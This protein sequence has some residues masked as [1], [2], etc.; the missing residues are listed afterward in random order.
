MR[1]A[2]CLLAATLAGCGWPEGLPAPRSPGPTPG[3]D[4][5]PVLQTRVGEFHDGRR[6]AA[7]IVAIED[8]ATLADRPGAIDMATAW[9]RYL[10]TT[11]RVSPWRISLLRDGQATAEAISAAVEK[12]H[13]GVGRPGTLWFVFIGH[14]GSTAPGEYGALVLQAGDGARPGL[15]AEPILQRL[16]Y[17]PHAR[18]VVVLDGCL[19]GAGA[20]VLAGS[21]TPTMPGFVA[22]ETNPD[23]REERLRGALGLAR[24]PREPVDAAV[25]SAGHGPGCVEQLPGAQFPALSYL[26][27][28]GLQGWADRDGNGTVTTRELISQ[29]TEMLR[30]ASQGLPTPAPAPRLFGPDMGLAHAVGARAPELRA[31][32]PRAVATDSSG[33]GPLAS[34]LQE[35]VLWTRDTAVHVPRGRFRMGCPSR[36]DRECEA[37]ERPAHSLYVSRF[38]LD[39]REVTHGEYA[40]CVARGLCDPVDRAQC[41]V[42]TGRRFER[43]AP[44]SRLLTRADHPAVCVTW[45]QAQRFCHVHDRRLPTEAEWERAAAGATRRRFP[46]GAAEPDCE[47]AHFDGCG[48]HTRPV[49][50]RPSGATPEGA[51]DMAGNAAEWVHDW[52]VRAIYGQWRD[53][54][55][56]GGKHGQVRVVRGGSYYDGPALLRSSYRY[57]LNPMSSFSTVGFRCLR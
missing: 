24:A 49:R 8:Y 42:W 23:L 56:Y 44:L 50:G 26:L 25:F 5:Y 13:A 37:D 41:F 55:P 21:E 31:W 53:R 30:A 14:V 36:D 57:G 39:A 9:Y 19:P 47:R 40:E 10:R 28:G 52:Y 12:A 1:A 3:G 45:Y 34:L 43:G 4:A 29:T 22:S 7:V 46:W 20:G 38:Q 48:E 35:P 11:Q 18:A 2:P 51:H 32:L 6:D 17:G 16:G 27:L 54:D 15:P 33:A